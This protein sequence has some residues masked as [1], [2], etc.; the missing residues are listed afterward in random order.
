MRDKYKP[1]VKDEDSDLPFNGDSE[2]RTKYG[3]KF[4]EV[5]KPRGEK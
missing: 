4:V 3:P 1:R 5:E 2:Y